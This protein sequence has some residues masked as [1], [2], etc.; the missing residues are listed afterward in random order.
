MNGQQKM[1]VLSKAITLRI[2]MGLITTQSYYGRILTSATH[3][4]NMSC[5]MK[6]TKRQKKSLKIMLQVSS[7]K[8]IFTAKLIEVKS[9]NFMLVKARA[10]G[11]AQQQR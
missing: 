3:S 6:T 5:S 8:R 1:K 2:G 11:F 9:T 4:E 10:G 7:S